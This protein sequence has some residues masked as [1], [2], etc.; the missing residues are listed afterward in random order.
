MIKRNSVPT[1]VLGKSEK[2]IC[3]TFLK[4]NISSLIVQKRA[5]K[6]DHHIRHSNTPQPL[7]ETLDSRSHEAH[8]A[9]GGENCTSPYGDWTAGFPLRARQ[10]AQPKTHGLP[11]DSGP[12]LSL[13]KAGSVLALTF[14]GV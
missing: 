4:I 2:C 13:H 8:D 12:P 9:S 11:Q 10:G 5:N 1:V 7:R 6:A 3:K 14:A